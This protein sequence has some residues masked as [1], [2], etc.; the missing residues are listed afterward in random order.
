METPLRV[1]RGLCEKYGLPTSG[2]KNKVLR[3]LREH[4]EILSRRLSDDKRATPTIQIDYAY[5]FTKHKHEIQQG[6]SEAKG[7]GDDG[8][9]GNPEVKQD[10]NFE[11]QHGLTLVG[12]E[13]TTGWTVKR[14]RQP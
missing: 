3:R 10:A 11:D 5:T 2:G 9:S 1:L 8:N 14:L 12:A 7:A 6:E 13:S 4:H